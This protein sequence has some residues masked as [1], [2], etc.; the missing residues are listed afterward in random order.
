M[1]SLISII[2][3]LFLVLAPFGL[4]PA[5]AAQPAYSGHPY[6]EILAVD[7][8]DSVTIRAYNLPRHDKFTVLQN[9]MGTRG[10][11]GVQVGTLSSGTSSSITQTYPIAEAFKDQKR[12]AIRIQSTTGSG[13]FAYNW[14]YHKNSGAQPPN[15]TTP[16]G[17]STGYTG[18]PTFSIKSVVRN[19]S[20]TIVTKNLP[21]DDTFAVKMNY[22]GTRGVNGW[23]VATLNSGD[24]GTQT[25][26]YNIPAELHG[27]RRI[28]IRLQSTSGSGYF[29]YNWFYN[30]TYP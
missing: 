10:R 16:P 2:V 11:N 5:S 22:M 17:S 23:T 29:A 27:Q 8:N 28:A 9:Y 7:K 6:I 18:Y 15:G 25:L 4:V 30:N 26:T 14:F 3:V 20:V 12:I 19:V 24:G 13:Y 21:P 1:K